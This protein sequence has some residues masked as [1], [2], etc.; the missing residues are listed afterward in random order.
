MGIFIW[1]V[2]AI[3]VTAFILWLFWKALEREALFSG[4]SIAFVLV[5]AGAITV[6]VQSEGKQ[7]PCFEYRTELIYNYSL[8]MTMPARVCVS[9]GEWVDSDTEVE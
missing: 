1:T 9:R 3:V 6:V 2:M 7:G 8:K 4:F 5:L